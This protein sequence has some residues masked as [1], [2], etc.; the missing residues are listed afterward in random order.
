VRDAEGRPLAGAEVTFAA[1]DGGGP[2]SVATPALASGRTDAR[3]RFALA[4]TPGVAGTLV[5]RRVGHAPA[6]RALSALEAGSRRELGVVLEARAQLD[7]VSVVAERERP[8]LAT[9]DASTGGTVERQELERLPTD[10]RDP[11]ALAA[12]VP[13][14]APATGFFGDAPRLTITGANALYT[15]YALDG[16]E[17][18]EGFLGGPR[19]ELPLSA[20]ARL[21]V[22]ATTYGAALGRSSNGVVD[23]ATRS[24]GERWTGEAFV[25]NRPGLPVDARAPWCR[26]PGHRRLPARTAGLP[27]HAGGCRSGRPLRARA[28]RRRRRERQRWQHRHWDRH[29]RVRCRRVHRRER[30]SRLVDRAGHLPRRELRQTWKLF[31]RVDHGWSPTQTTTLRVAASAVDREGRGSGIVAP[32][33][34]IV[35]QRAG[36]ATA[37]VH[38]TALRDG[39]ASHVRA[40]SS[41]RS[42]GTSPRRGARSTCR[43]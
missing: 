37:L 32:E 30:G 1:T 13:G 17:N 19:V 18:N 23:M 14:V 40:C 3:G 7:V 35:T 12:T 5:V 24:G 25:Y 22:Q 9:R 15:Q 36:T 16:L 27:P 20:L 4:V 10:R 29:L 2:G 28:A 41:G 43:R 38:R 34:D 8:L 6:T 42:A 33:A 21:A 26:R 31:G 11:I 39:R